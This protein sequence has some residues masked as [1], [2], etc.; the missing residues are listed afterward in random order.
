VDR[1]VAIVEAGGVWIDEGKVEVGRS[2]V[3][4]VGKENG[5]IVKPCCEGKEVKE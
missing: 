2:R 4:K 5:S 1:D 3:K